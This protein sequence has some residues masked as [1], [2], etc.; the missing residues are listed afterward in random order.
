[1]HERRNPC[2]CAPCSAPRCT[3]SSGRP[4]SDL[5]CCQPGPARLTLPPPTGA[6][7][8]VRM[9]EARPGIAFVEY[10]NDMQASLAM[11][12]LQGFKITPTNA[13]AITYAK[14]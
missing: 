4:T 3:A 8:Q 5:A 7:L 13:M 11:S 9:V 2:T 10:E 1:M 14:Q 6:L 12:G